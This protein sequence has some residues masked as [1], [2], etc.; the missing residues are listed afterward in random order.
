MGYV[1]QLASSVSHESSDVK[2]QVELAWRRAFGR[3]ATD[4]EIEQSLACIADQTQRLQELKSK[5]EV[6][7]VIERAKRPYRD[8]LA[9]RFDSMPTTRS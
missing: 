2:S 4:Q 3:P 6:E 7:S 9:L 8:G 1:R 5:F